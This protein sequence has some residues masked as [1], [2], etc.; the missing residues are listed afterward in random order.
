MISPN[1]VKIV[2]FLID[3]EEKESR[4]LKTGEEV[5][6]F[7]KLKKLLEKKYTVEVNDKRWLNI[8]ID[9]LY[10]AYLIL[11]T[12]NDYCFFKIIV[13]SRNDDYVGN[14]SDIEKF[15]EW[16]VENIKLPD[17]HLSS[18]EIFACFSENLEIFD[19]LSNVKAASI[20]NETLVQMDD[21]NHYAVMPMKN[22]A[23]KDVRVFKI[24][25]LNLWRNIGL[26]N[27][28]YYKIKRFWNILERN[29]DWVEDIYRDIAKNLDSLQVREKSTG[30]LMEI[31]GNFSEELPKISSLSRALK[32]DRESINANIYNTKLLFK[33]L[34]EK[35]YEEYPTI[36]CFIL[37][38]ETFVERG[39][40]ILIE[41][42]G[43]VKD[44]LNTTT[45]IIRGMVAV[46]Q[47][48]RSTVAQE[49][50][51][52]QATALA[53]LQVVFVFHSAI[54]VWSY[55]AW[56]VQGSVWQYIPLSTKFGVAFT[57]AFAIPLFAFL[58]VKKK[59]KLAIFYLAL[60]LAALG[61]AYWSIILFQSKLL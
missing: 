32:E 34:R 55:F 60:I 17:N 46:D 14:T 5:V 4:F 41:N 29:H 31:L 28:Y 20:F 15:R 26:I 53:V 50:G 42:I 47:E 2:S 48:Q 8:L 45:N 12:G 43:A 37:N 6:I 39:F 33:T 24:L 35:P 3:K 49:Q 9:D 54:E 18:V 38:E 40:S 51:L 13:T 23:K 21:K 27:V 7:N 25:L 1:Y 44:D 61:V 56:S 52:I 16:C 58:L 11:H 30:D 36:S 59:W 19:F 22:I 10:H 57:L